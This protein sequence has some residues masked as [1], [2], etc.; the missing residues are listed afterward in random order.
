MLTIT[1]NMGLKVIKSWNQSIHY[2][3]DVYIH[4]YKK[5]YIIEIY[6]TKKHYLYK[7]YS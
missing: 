4:V 1:K 2:I 7:L 6:V 5:D 3:H